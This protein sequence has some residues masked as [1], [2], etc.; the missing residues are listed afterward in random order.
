VNEEKI[1]ANVS[2]G[3]GIFKKK[4]VLQRFEIKVSEENFDL[5]WYIGVK[6]L[7]YVVT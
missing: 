7:F 1:F 5:A 3:K 6:N 4:S 2:A